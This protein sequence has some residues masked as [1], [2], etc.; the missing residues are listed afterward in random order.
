MNN[1][2]MKDGIEFEM[3]KLVFFIVTYLLITDG[4]EGEI[5]NYAAFY[6]TLFIFS[7]SAWIDNLS[8][9]RFQNRKVFQRYYDG[10]DIGNPYIS[11][12]GSIVGM[13]TVTASMYFACKGQ[14]Q[15]F[16]MAMTVYYASSVFIGLKMW[17]I[18]ESILKLTKLNVRLQKMMNNKK[19]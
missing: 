17:V 10:S 3:L 1:K 5:I 14:E 12:I 9:L 16:S 2:E 15:Y 11:L 13:F 19:R 8:E 7:A 18:G 4:L 6:S